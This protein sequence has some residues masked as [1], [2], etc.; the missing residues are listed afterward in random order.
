[1]KMRFKKAVT[2]V[3]LLCLLAV[4][5]TGCEDLDYRDAIDLYNSGNYTKAAE[6]FAVL[7]DF[8]DSAHMETLC[9]YWIAVDTMQSGDYAAAIP[10]LEA[11]NGYEDTAARVTECQY[12][13]ALQS[14]AQ[15]DLATA[16]NGFLLAP[17][18]RQAP[19]YL[20]QI[21]WQKFFDTVAVTPLK[22]EKDGKTFTLTVNSENDRL[23][24]SVETL[25]DKGYSFGNDLTMTVSR[26]SMI[27]DF[28]AND[29]FAMEFKDGTIGTEQTMAGR[30]DI[31]ACT[32]ETIP[33]VDSF[34]KTVV[35]NQGNTTTTTDLADSLMT[36][37]MLANF[38]DMMTVIPEMIAEAAFGLTLH[39]I[40]FSAM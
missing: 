6:M 10:L 15:G 31:T 4:S 1:M 34:E 8:E 7:G 2:T 27:A 16:E 3:V 22:A 26:D 33:L 40:G 29:H 12:Q 21:T 36:D 35:D 37:E 24:F 19:E 13:L 28:T 25:T 30:I 14:F 9:H 11:M 39:D 18:Y 5:M 38:Q 20:R 32:A 23:V 17:E